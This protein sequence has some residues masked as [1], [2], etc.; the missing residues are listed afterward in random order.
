MSQQIKY[1]H[2]NLI[3]SDWKKLAE[4]YIRV[5]GCKPIYPERHLSGEWIENL[6]KIN[7]VEMN[8]IHLQLPGY[9]D[10]GPTL[11]IFEFN[12]K[13][14]VQTHQINDF[15]FSHIAF[16]VD[17]VEEML[18]TVVEN[19]GQK[20]GELVKTEIAG[21]GKLTAIYVRDIEGN[22]VELQNWEK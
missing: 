5:F 20:Y 16:H 17:N 11:E 9:T 4:F 8:G 15:G 12:K 18:A 3:A 22:I 6:T 10:N 14:N 2:T 13:N 21:V 19:G 7:N 1:V